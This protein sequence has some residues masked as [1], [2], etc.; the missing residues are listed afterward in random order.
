MNLKNV[1]MLKIK[2]IFYCFTGPNVKGQLISKCLY[3]IFN[4]PKKRTKNFDFTTMVTSSQI[5]FLR[6]LGELKA[7][8]IH[9]EIN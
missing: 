7:P 6:F 2:L 4:F 9:F 8:K 5:V 1:C 3:G